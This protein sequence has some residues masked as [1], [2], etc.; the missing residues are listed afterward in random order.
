MIRAATVLMLLTAV[1]ASAQR[2]PFDADDFLDQRATGGQPVLISRVVIGAASN[3][4]DSFRPLGEH[5]GYVHLANSFYWRSVQLDYKR[6]ELRAEEGQAERW[7]LISGTDNF[8]GGQLQQRRS[9]TPKS[10]DTLN[11][12]WYWTI[13]A[14]GESDPVLL[15]SRVTFATQ[16]VGT[17]VFYLN[18][19]LTH[20]SGRDRTFALDSDTWFRVAGHDV[21]GS[22]AVSRTKTTGT[23]SD[24]DEKALTY[25]NRFPAVSYDRATVL[26]RPTLTVGGISNRGA[27]GVN[28]VNPAI[29]IFRPF[30]HTG[31]NLHVIW[32]PQWIANGGGWKVTH[33]V[34][35]F[36]DRA[37]FVKVFRD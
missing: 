3:I 35:V 36:V 1:T 27:S 9:A 19:R 16:P 24:R 15:R 33:Q 14:R 12:A 2:P 17:D 13:P 26:I 20:L 6:S 30:V 25:T 28:L 32:S 22:L 21:F 37:L 5:V 29:E 10:K 34:V 31:T 11:A 18:R 8:T 7:E 4:S 23:L